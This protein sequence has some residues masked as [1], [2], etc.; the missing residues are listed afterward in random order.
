[1]ITLMLL[2]SLL[3]SPVNPPVNSVKPSIARVSFLKPGGFELFTYVDSRGNMLTGNR[4]YLNYGRNLK[5]GLG[6][7]NFTRIT[8]RLKFGSTYGILSLE[9]SKDI[10]GGKI[11]IGYQQSF[12]LQRK[13][14]F[15]K[16]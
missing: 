16:N 4:F 7:L 3:G 11:K 2:I 12:P 15:W 10:W 5:I 9:Y 8:D 13:D 14:L 1:M 6:I